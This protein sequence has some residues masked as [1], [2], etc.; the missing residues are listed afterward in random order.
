[1]ISKNNNHTECFIWIWLPE[2]ITPVVAGKIAL[3][4]NKYC[5]T[6]SQSYRARSDAIAL[7]AFELPLQS[8]T[9]VPTG[10]NDIHSCLRDASPDAW[11]RRL[12]HYQHPTLNANEI[13]FL[14]LSGSNRIGALDFQASSEAYI[15]R[16]N[17][18]DNMSVI[19]DLAS[20]IESNK[21][22][23]PELIPALLHGTSIG[24]ARPKCT[25]EKAGKNCIAKFS[26][27]TDLYPIIKSEYIAMKLAK[28]IGIDV[29]NVEYISAHGRDILLIERF[30]RT[31]NKNGW[32]RHNILSGLSLLGLNEMEARYASYRDLADI[33]RQHFFKPQKTLEELFKRLVFNIICGNTDDHARN[34]SALWD[35]NHLVLSPAYDLCPQLRTGQEATQAMAIGGSEGNFSTLTNALSIHDKFLLNLQYAKDIINMQ[36]E[37]TQ[38]YWPLL[39]EEV[40]LSAAEQK[41]LWGNVICSDYCLLKWAS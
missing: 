28:Q 32:Q 24:G 37:Q 16:E 1:M 27:S 5:F 31:R 9:F 39:C 10:M 30:D 18:L 26:L 40:E 15:S 8:G 29:A 20:I 25:L 36:L 7:S 12:I 6:Y 4:E 35:G 2:Q 21:Q 22:F 14:L 13:D 38:K 11:G 19:D 23:S 3:A 34:H 41:M 17:K 33:I